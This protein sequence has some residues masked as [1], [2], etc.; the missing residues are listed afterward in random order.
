M[1]TPEVFQ[2]Q[3]VFAFFL[4]SLTDASLGALKRIDLPEKC[5]RG[6]ERERKSYLNLARL[7][8]SKA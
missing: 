2:I 3:K 5:L 8:K 1:F 4:V 7:F 6:R